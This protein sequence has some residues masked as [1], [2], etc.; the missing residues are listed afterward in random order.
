MPGARAL[1]LL[2]EKKVKVCLFVA[3]REELRI[4]EV[5]SFSCD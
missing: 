4:R 1:Q 2:D 3:S 5:V